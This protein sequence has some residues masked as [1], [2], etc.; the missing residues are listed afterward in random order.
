MFSFWGPEQTSPC[1]IFREWG[2]LVLEKEDVMWWEIA[3]GA[4]GGRQAT[5][6]DFRR[7]PRFQAGDTRDTRSA[8]GAPGCTRDSRSWKDRKTDRPAV[9]NQCRH[10]AGQCG[11]VGAAVGMT[12]RY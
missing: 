12:I 3:R 7:S 10:P 5:P 11:T 9:I 4:G 1:R 6:R 8:P 2:D